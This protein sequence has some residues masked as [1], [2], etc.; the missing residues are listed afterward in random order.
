MNIES[1]NPINDNHLVRYAGKQEG[2][3]VYVGSGRALSAARRAQCLRSPRFEGMELLCAHGGAP[4][5]DEGNLALVPTA[6]V[7]RAGEAIQQPYV[8]I[9]PEEVSK[10]GLIDLPECFFSGWYVVL[11]AYV[12]AEVCKGQRVVPLYGSPR[13]EM[14]DDSEYVTVDAIGVVEVEDEGSVD[15]GS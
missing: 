8:Q 9:V 6:N 4:I 12:G 3:I 2:R 15:E 7:I 5:D 10:A 11:D 14:E 1:I 13:L